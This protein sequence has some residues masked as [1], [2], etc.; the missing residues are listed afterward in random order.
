ME[1]QLPSRFVE[2][3]RI[4]KARG[5]DGT[6]R[7]MP[8]KQFFID[9]VLSESSIL[10][11]RNERSDLVPLRIEKV[12]RESKRNH[13]SFFVKFDLIA[14]R[15]E[16]DAARDKALFADKSVAGANPLPAVESDDDFFGY[17]IIFQNRLIGEVLDVMET[18]A[19]PILEVKLESGTGGVLLIPFVNEFVE[20]V[21]HQNQQLICKELD[22]LTDL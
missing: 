8:G 17:E 1:Q 12:Y 7:F 18:P 11:M 5:L 15:E 19:H 2:I 13:Q 21:D 14:S 3:G 22:Q 16:A 4:G 20:S 6:I 10:Y 9:E